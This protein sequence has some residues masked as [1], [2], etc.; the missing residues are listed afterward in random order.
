MDFDL[1]TLLYILFGII[2]FVFASGKKKNKNTPKRQNRPAN[3]QP[4]QTATDRRKP[5]FE[6]LL[7]EFTGNKTIIP[8]PA[9]A[10]IPKPVKVYE[11]PKPVP[12]LKEKS[13]TTAYDK[14]EHRSISS[15]FAKF[16]EFD[17]DREEKK[18]IDDLHDPDTARKAF[19]YSEIFRRKY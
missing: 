17:G 13:I 16:D 18:F 9:P 15:P 4:T 8:E 3:P 19:I 12:T 5:T 1:S 2:Y 6:E 14:L 7:E 10:P 11:A